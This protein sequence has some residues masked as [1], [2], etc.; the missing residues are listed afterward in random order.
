MSRAA[1]KKP[2]AI[3]ALKLK[4]SSLFRSQAYVGG[5]WVDADSGKTIDV[6]NPATDEVIGTV[7]NLAGAETKRAIEAAHKAWDGWRSM[8]AADRAKILKKWADLQTEHLDDLCKILTT[9]QGKPL[10]QAKAEIMSGIAYVE[11][12]AEEGR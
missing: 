4:D 1:A 12:M 6:N 11:W 10:S 9:E 2:D 3:S 8:L 7:P 5:E